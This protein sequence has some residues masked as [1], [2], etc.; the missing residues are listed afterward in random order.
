[1]NIQGF[2]TLTVLDFPGHTACTVFTGGCNLRCPFCHNVQLVLDPDG[3]PGVPEEEFF[4][5]LARRRGVLDGVAVTGGEP[6]LQ[7]DLAAFLRRVKDAGF[8]VK[9]DT[10]GFFPERFAA[11]LSEGLVDYVAMDIK[12]SPAKY[13]ATC[14]RDALDL[15]LLERSVALLKTSAVDHEFRTTVTRELHTVEDIA[16]AAQMIAGAPRYYLQAF[17]DSGILSEGSCTAP[18]EETLRA[19]AVAAAPFVGFV[20]IRGI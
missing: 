19:M 2:Q 11:L 17:K 20:G 9:L 5:F 14:G 4:A 12:N 8:L 15:S 13:A 1:M 16:A 10:N 6:L 18:E 7:P 3:G